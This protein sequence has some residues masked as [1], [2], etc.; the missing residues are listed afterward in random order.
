MSVQCPALVADLVM[1]RARVSFFS[2][3]YFNV[4]RLQ[5]T[6]KRVS[7]FHASEERFKNALAQISYATT[8]FVKRISQES[9]S[10]ASDVVR[11][12]KA[13]GHFE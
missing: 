3:N 11:P 7:L 8:T 13:L 9:S 5:H 10:L 2:R 12:L 6:F 4:Q 1:R